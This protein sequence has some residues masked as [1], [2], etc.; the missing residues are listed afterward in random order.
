MQDLEKGFFSIF[1]R[2]HSSQAKVRRG[3]STERRSPYRFNLKM[4]VWA[5]QWLVKYMKRLESPLVCEYD[6]L[7]IPILNF[8]FILCEQHTLNVFS[9]F[10]SNESFVSLSS[11]FWGIKICEPETMIM[12]SRFFAL[13][14]QLRRGRLGSLLFCTA[15]LRAPITSGHDKCTDCRSKLV[16]HS[17]HQNQGSLGPLKAT[18]YNMKT[19][20]LAC[21]HLNRTQTDH[22][23]LAHFHSSLPWV[24]L[25]EVELPC[26]E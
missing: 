5:D 6:Q 7:F 21:I 14:P 10:L 13:F 2:F 12:Q 18:K 9:L 15:V 11:A 23:S 8:C 22:G 24:S 26:R 17:S 4:W 16:S 25:W 1:L 19:F 20:T 3:C